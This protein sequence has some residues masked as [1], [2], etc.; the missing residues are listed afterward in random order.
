[1][2]VSISADQITL[3]DQLHDNLFSSAESGKISLTNSQLSQFSIPSMYQ[4]CQLCVL[5][6]KVCQM[7][8][9]V[10]GVTQKMSASVSQSVSQW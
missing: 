3:S 7:S 1:M 8:T 10:K 4:S 5:S 2:S 9:I 6:C